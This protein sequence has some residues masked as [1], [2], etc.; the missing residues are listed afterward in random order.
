MFLHFLTVQE[1]L[2]GRKILGQTNNDKTAREKCFFNSHTTA[3]NKPDSRG[4]WCCSL[5]SKP[6]FPVTRVS[7]LIGQRWSWS[8][9]SVSTLARA[10]KV[11]CRLPNLWLPPRLAHGLFKWGWFV[12]RWQRVEVSLR[13]PCWV[14][15]VK[16]AGALSYW[17]VSWDTETWVREHFRLRLDGI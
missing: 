9:S 6:S 15:W 12:I 10:H 1:L 4:R 3:M 13:S 14:G 7:G 11:S 8:T 2:L 16:I 17:M 5:R